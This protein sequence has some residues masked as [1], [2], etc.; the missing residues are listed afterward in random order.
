MSRWE[1]EALYGGAAGGGK[2]DA[3][4]MEGLRQ[5]GIPHYRGLI[6]RK[7]YP[8]LSELIDR[9]RQLYRAAYPG[10]VYH[11]GEHCWRFP[12]GAQIHFGSMQHPEDRGQYQGKRFD[13][14][15]VDELTHFTLE[16]YMYLFSRNRPGGPGTRV[17]MRAATN[18]GGIG[19]GWVK[20]RF[21][22]PAPPMATIR[23][24]VEYL[25]GNGRL[26]KSVRSRIFVPA[27]VADNRAL[28]K[29]DPG[30]PARLAMLPSAVREALLNGSW[31][32]FSGQVFTEWRNDPAGYATQKNTHVIAP[33]PIPD[34]W[35][36]YRGFDWGY[37]K[38]FAVGWFA[39]DENRRLYHIREYYG[40]TGVPDTGL[41][42]EPAQAAAKIR[43]IEE[44][45]PLL[46]GRK[47][48]GVADPAI[49]QHQTG[50]SIAGL[51]EQERVY[52]TPGDHSRLPGKM[53]LHYRLRFDENGFPLF[54]VFNTCRNFIRTVPALTYG[55]RDPEDINTACE[56]HIYDM[57]RYVLMENPVTAP[58]PIPPKRKGPDPL[59]VL[60]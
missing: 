7:T 12:G 22:T 19:H 1:D 38:P 34:H 57:T 23:E 48:H 5:A 60:R 11:A 24:P 16:E 29:N 47:I 6:L 37:S 59:D 46:K 21:I 8:Q 28:L 49:F 36:V 54:Y 51:M 27:R 52:F 30:Y 39:V 25:G 42:M 4:L 55:S 40:S 32:T 18:P 3:L 58:L 33:F 41:R 53:Q 43:E 35:R 44:T 10:A 15:A 45:D 20:E 9:S 50:L 17:Y 13:Y 56:D 26:I 14:I 2:S 31:D